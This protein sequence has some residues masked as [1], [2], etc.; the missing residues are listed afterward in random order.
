MDITY[1][2]DMKKIEIRLAL[3]QL[4]RLEKI[5]KEKEQ[6]LITINDIIVY[7]SG[8]ELQLCAIHHKQGKTLILVNLDSGTIY[9]QKFNQ[10]SRS[11]SLSP[12]DLVVHF[13]ELVFPINNILESFGIKETKF[14]HIKR[15]T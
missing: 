2:I 6:R 12:N 1:Q 7:H 9:R 8:T 5:K 4:N 3:E 14:S 13:N 15:I 10:V 11:L